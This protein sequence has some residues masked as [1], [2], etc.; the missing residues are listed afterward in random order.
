[1]TDC[2]QNPPLFLFFFFE[3]MFNALHLEMTNRIVPTN[4]PT[5]KKMPIHPWIMEKGRKK[6]LK[7][8]IVFFDDNLNKTLGQKTYIDKKEDK[9]SSS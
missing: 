3:Y 9:P 2:G 5:L 7:R 1:M 4:P 8:R 6:K